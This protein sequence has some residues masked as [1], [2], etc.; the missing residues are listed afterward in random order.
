LTFEVEMETSLAEDYTSMLDT[1]ESTSCELT[2]GIQAF[3]RG[4][5]KKKKKKLLDEGSWF[6]KHRDAIK[7]YV[8]CVG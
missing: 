7:R 5:K 8:R 6:N 1:T 2:A 4:E 3:D